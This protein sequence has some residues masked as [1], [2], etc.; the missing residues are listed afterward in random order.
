MA[1]INRR[2]F[3]RTTAT[4]GAGFWI[5]GRQT[6]YGQE[7]SANAKLNIPSVGCGGQGAWRR[8]HTAPPLH[9]SKPLPR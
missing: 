7:K 4:A 9:A 3:I 1:R 8:G 2:D 6:G 5:A